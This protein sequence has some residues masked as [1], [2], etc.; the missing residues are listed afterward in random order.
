M[1]GKLLCATSRGDQLAPVDKYRKKNKHKRNM[2]SENCI[3]VSEGTFDIRRPI[4]N[5]YTG[6]DA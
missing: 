5:E 6:R 4:L 1:G 3:S 2:K